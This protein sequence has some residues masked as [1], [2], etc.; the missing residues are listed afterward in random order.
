MKNQL[1][2][3]LLVM[4]VAL[5][6][7]SCLAQQKS[8]IHD[9][10]N[11]Y[12]DSPEN[13]GSQLTPNWG[14]GTKWHYEHRSMFP[15]EVTTMTY[16]ITD[17]TTFK[18]EQ[19]FILNT[20]LGDTYLKQSDGRVWIYIEEM[21]DYQLTYD[22]NLTH[23]TTFLWDAMCPDTIDGAS[24]HTGLMT[25]DSIKDFTLPDGSASQLQYVNYKESTPMAD[26]GE[27]GRRAIKNVGFDYGGLGLNTGYLICD[28]VLN[29]VSDLRCFENDGVLY[30]FVG[31]P[32]DSTWLRVSTEDLDL[33]D[34]KV[35]PNPSRGSF[36]VETDD[37]GP[38]A[39]QIFS[40]TGQKLLSAET[41]ERQIDVDVAPGTY[42]LRLKIGEAWL[43]RR[44]I[45]E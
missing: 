30:N 37:A 39:Y 43:D 2:Q 18:G 16:E 23:Q 13:E 11:V 44:L 27:F 21:D 19:V 29:H 9:F 33:Q 31:Y 26:Y 8:T 45:I 17:T 7:Y 40:L 22:F 5:L 35:Y 34:V 25:V 41:Y 4:A 32:C 36:K 10:G 38:V 15:P 42:L 20:P 24:K 6:S 14:I 1:T 28:C 12:S 3:L